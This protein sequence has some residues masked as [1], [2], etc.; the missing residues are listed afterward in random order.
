M[1]TLAK[2]PEPGR[3]RA[4]AALGGALGALGANLCAPLFGL[5]HASRADAAEAAGSLPP[6]ETVV[7][8][9]DD[10]RLVGIGVSRSGRV[11]ATAPSSIKRSRYSV[12]E[13]DTGTGSLHAFPDGDWNRYD[14][15][16]SGEQQWISAQAMWFDERDHLWVLDSSLPSVDQRRQPP[17]IVQFDINTGKVLRAYTYEDT[18]TPKDSINDIRI[19]LKHGYAYISNAGNQGGVVVTRLSDG[20]SRLVLAGDRS[21]V[22]DP[23][24]HLMFGDRIARKPDGGIVVLQTDGIAIS[25]QRDW[26]YYR[27]LTDHHYWRIPTDA[28]IDE[29]L[30]PAAL[31]QR[32]QYLGDYALTGGLL[33][34]PDGVLYG[35]D[36]EHRTVVALTP[37]ERDGKPALEQ[38]VLVDDPKKRLSWADGFA[39]QND[40]LYIS[41]SHLPETNF[42]NGYPREGRFTIFRVKLPKQPAGLFAG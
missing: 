19:D 24:Q 4:V 15:N 21:S 34:S 17:K 13:V 33:M 32:V 30:S 42:S 1:K 2:D 10:F 5:V 31:A 9:G 20:K 18:V 25:P 3:R 12:V 7:T 27:P 6:L 39:Q 37:V 26:L 8:F 28:L 35:G 23:N 14:P 40:Y 22:S 29:S 36:L 11:F 41:D 38:R 16:A